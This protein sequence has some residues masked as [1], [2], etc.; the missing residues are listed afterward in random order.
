LLLEKRTI[1]S[2]RACCTKPFVAI[3]VYGREGER[4]R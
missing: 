4:V 3:I 1:G 2:H